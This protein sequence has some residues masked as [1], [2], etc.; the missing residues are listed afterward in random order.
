[1]V[2]G[3]LCKV[4]QGNSRF[5]RLVWADT[6]A[7]LRKVAVVAED[8]EV[9]G[10]V[11]LDQPKV[12]VH[13][14]V[15]KVLPPLIPIVVDVIYRQ[16]GL[17]SLTTARTRIAI[18]G[19]YCRSAFKPNGLLAVT[20]RFTGDSSGA[21]WISTVAEPCG[22]IGIVPIPL[23]LHVGMRLPIVPAPST[24]TDRLIVGLP[25]SCHIDILQWYSALVQHKKISV[26]PVHEHRVGRWQARTIR[27]YRLCWRAWRRITVRMGH[28]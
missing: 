28:S 8:L 6:S 2:G 20:T 27:S 24:T 7:A 13:M 9:S 21:L 4:G 17:L 16:E 18:V 22:E 1:M 15:L 19:E 12:R 23:C 5:C 3:A 25:F 26:S 14:V 10:E 11:V